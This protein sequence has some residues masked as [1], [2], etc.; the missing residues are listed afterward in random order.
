MRK[1]IRSFT[2]ITI[3]CLAIAQ[4]SFLVAAPIPK[5]PNLNVESYIIMD[6]SSGAIIASK[7]PD[8]PLPP[9]SIT[10]IMTSYI[11]FL[12]LRDGSMRLDDQVL[13]SEKAWKTGGSKMFIEVG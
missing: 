10:K 7:I 9:A 3:F 13:I 5:P 11:A 1:L 4:H 8:V 12:E 2:S 6:F